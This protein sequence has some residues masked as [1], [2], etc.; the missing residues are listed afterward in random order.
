[1]S[2]NIFRCLQMSS[3]VIK[4]LKIIYFFCEPDISYIFP[5]RIS[6]KRDY[7]NSALNSKSLSRAVRVLKSGALVLT[8]YIFGR[9]PTNGLAFLKSSNVNFS[10][11]FCFYSSA[12]VQWKIKLS[13]NQG[14]KKG[15]LISH[16]GHARLT[17]EYR[18]IEHSWIESDLRITNF[19]KNN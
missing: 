13:W 19:S 18:Q 17:L 12:T 7:T 9:K 8:A 16:W 6:P 15:A 11:L 2:S 4:Y 10:T 5:E 14:W 1:M 3:N